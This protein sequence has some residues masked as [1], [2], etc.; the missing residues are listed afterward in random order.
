MHALPRRPAWTL[1]LPT[2]PPR[3]ATAPGPPA[4]TPTATA[5]T[6]ASDGTDATPSSHDM[7]I[8]PSLMA[9]ARDLATVPLVDRAAAFDELNRDVATA[10]RAIEDV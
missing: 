3:R 4:T 5:A 2:P 9:R 1:A 7:G 6:P 8:D 10:L